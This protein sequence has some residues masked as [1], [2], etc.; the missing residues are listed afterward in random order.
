MVE[1]ERPF[2]DQQSV[3][4][5]ESSMVG[6]LAALGVAPEALEAVDMH[7]AVNQCLVLIDAP[8]VEAVE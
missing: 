3:V 1:A 6:F 7:F 5:L 4:K 8:V 2:S